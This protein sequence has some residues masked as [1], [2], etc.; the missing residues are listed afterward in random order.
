LKWFNRQY[1]LKL[2]DKEFVEH[3]L[4]FLP[5]WL[6]LESQP[7]KSTLL[8]RL[9]P[10][11]KDKISAFGEIKSLFDENGE[12]RFV[13]KLTDY[14]AESLLWKKN[15]DKAATII[16]LKECRRLIKALPSNDSNTDSS[17]SQSLASGSFMAESIKSAIWPYAEAKGKGEVLWPLRVALTGQE[18]SPDPFVSASILGREESLK[19]IDAALNKLA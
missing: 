15:P 4:R 7:A 9:L 10:L 17:A 12:L 19:R 8:D 11:I 14:K 6:S 16:H 5:E 18:K 2:S 13:N 3:S 1:L